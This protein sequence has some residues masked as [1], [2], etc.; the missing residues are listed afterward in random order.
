M[1]QE[2]LDLVIKILI[3]YP[4]CDSCLGRLFSRLGGNIG[5]AER[6]RALK[7]VLSIQSHLLL[8]NS[9][10]KGLE[11]LNALY[12]SGFDE[13][14]SI[15]EKFN[16][17]A[18]AEKC[19]I[20]ENLM[21]K[22]PDIAE[23]ISKEVSEFEF[24]TFM[25]GSIIPKEFIEREDQIRSLYSLTHG[26][27]L[28]LDF[29]RQLGRSLESSLNKIVNFD[30]P[31]IT[32]VYNAINDT[33]ELS[34]RPVYVY[35]RYL[36]LI[37]GISQTRQF[38]PH[39]GGKGCEHCN[40]TGFLPGR[41]V[42]D[43]LVPPIVEAHKGAAGVLHAGGRED[44][45]VRTLG[46]GRPFVVEV[47][48]P[49]KRHVNL[50]DLYEAIEKYSEGKITVKNL[51]YVDRSIVK[52]INVYSRIHEKRYR[53]VIRFPKTQIRDDII[54]KIKS[55]AGI[56]IRQR[57]PRRVLYRRVDK[58]RVKRIYSIEP[59]L[60]DEHTIELNILCQGGLY[61]KEFATSDEGR[62]KPSIAEIVGEIPEIVELDVIEIAPYIEKQLG[63]PCTG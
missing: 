29:N 12:R 33:V 19:S 7:R 58:E 22:I 59:R 54:N 26:E 23:R 46:T 24:D 49:R 30:K 15:Y 62:T 38:C 53:I 60:I 52:K 34:L 50:H 20:C 41:S 2:L 47:K 28:K 39:C 37:R 45:D 63:L 40:Y 51:C 3:N 9:D 36:K 44:I 55:L 43:Y 21:L 61:V 57:T 16:V 4:L 1:T 18:S 35:G 56:T 5:N 13:A 48:N 27:S 11:I 6:G 8:L 42:E 10:D 25:V 14:L 32:I 31:D 17:T